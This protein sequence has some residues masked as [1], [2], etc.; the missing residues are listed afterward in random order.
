VALIAM[1][2]R[3]R[4]PDNALDALKALETKQPENP[5]THNLRGLALLQ[6]SDFAGA[7]TSFERCLK[8]N[9]SYMP[10][11]AHL[12]QLDLRDKKPDAARARYEA[13]LSKQPNNE[14]ALAGLAVVLRTSGAPKEEVEKVLVRAAASSSNS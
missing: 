2:L 4:Q 5:L 14:Q 12:A 10:A 1:Y 11:V 8:L 3:Q 13:I 6:K 7:R 9:A